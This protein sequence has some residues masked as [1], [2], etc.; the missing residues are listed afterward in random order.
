MRSLAL[1]ALL[2]AGSGLA[3][4][5]PLH[6]HGGQYR[7]PGDTVPPG[8][9]GSS[10]GGAAPGIAGPTGPGGTSPTTGA[11]GVRGPGGPGNSPSQGGLTGGNDPGLDLSQ[12]S[13]WWEFNKEPFLDLRQY[14]HAPGSVT[15]SDAWFL[16]NGERSQGRDSLRPSE[17]QIRETVVPALLAALEHETNNDVV[18]GCL[19]A[20]AK[21]GDPPGES[22]ASPIGATI[23]RYLADANQEISETAAIA[24][25]I[26]GNPGEIES[27]VGVLEDRESGR[28]LLG[29]HEVPLR[30][31]AFSAYALGLL[32]SRCVREEDR[33]T[34]VAAL[35][36]SLE[37]GDQRARD[38]PV[39]CVI[40]LGMTPLAELEA[41]PGSAPELGRS[42]QVEHLLA[43]LADSSQP[44]LVRAHAPTA[45]ARLLTG[46][47]PPDLHEALRTR[48]A[49]ALLE[50]LSPRS[51]D[52]VEIVQSVALA[53]G[54]LGTNDLESPLDRSI[55]EA[56][57]G[58]ARNG[59]AQ[60]RSF[61][62]ISLARVGART[63]AN[64][65]DPEGGLDLVTKTLLHSLAE[66]KGQVPSWAGLACGVLARE[67]A[68]S[69]QAPSRI[70]ALQNAV[71]GALAEE[72]STE[73][74]AALAIAAGIMRDQ[75]AAPELLK[76]LASLRDDGARGYVALSLGLMNAREALDEIQTVVG[77][78]RFRPELLKQA[79]IALG[80]L[81]DKNAVSVLSDL[82]RSAKG[83][84][85]QASVSSA[86][87]IIGDRRS[88]EPLVALLRNPDLTPSARG[89]AAAALGIVADRAHLPWN[90]SISRDLNYRAST[91]TLTDTGSGTG[92]LDLL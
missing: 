65:S 10:P 91:S 29:R 26:L 85:T 8:G 13:F 76:R 32:G 63:A 57:T 24:L 54:L 77:E 53:L 12:W 35:R 90:S 11:P 80:L 68:S 36:Q 30:T 16:G 83:L 71:R 89:F 44:A 72:R 50:S 9:T 33:R 51:K 56:L 6:A 18:T 20:L 7:G 62:L 61:A 69:R 17:S 88:V 70:A 4:P 19:I 79:S 23:A 45:L 21:I 84:A 22:G 82:L 46:E 28:R 58:L 73:R 42:A 66:G 87:G 47:L 92:I 1:L 31:R 81:G 27:L 52:P 39:A 59:E 25:G 40:A 55:L 75:E 37:A 74:V 15:G 49:S 2:A 41:P 67:L 64:S 48:I 14:L 78:A 60:S 43:F 5:S 38:L 34:I 86:L 3:L